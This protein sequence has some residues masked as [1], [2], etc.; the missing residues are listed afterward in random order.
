MMTPTVHLNGT[1][2]GELERQLENAVAKVREAIEAL[3]D[4]APNARDYY[5]QGSDAFATAQSEHR[6][7]CASLARVR[8]ELE[9]MWE[10]IADA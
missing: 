9:T 10:A 4:A 2:K 6:T 7:R 8:G 1:S 5:P 3:I